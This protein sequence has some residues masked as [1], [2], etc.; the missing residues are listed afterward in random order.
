MI[1]NQQLVIKNIKMENISNLSFEIEN[2]L[3]I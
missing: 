1:D 2:L 3:S